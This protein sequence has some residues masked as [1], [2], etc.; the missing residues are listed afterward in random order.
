MTTMRDSDSVRYR[1]SAGEGV[2]CRDAG[3]PEEHVRGEHLDPTRS[4]IHSRRTSS[5]DRIGARRHLTT[6]VPLEAAGADTGGC[7]PEPPSARRRFG[8]GR[9]QFDCLAASS[10]GGEAG[11]DR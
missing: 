2:V 7:E 1:T 9:R 10:R 5:P 6:C 11:R 8:S 3:G 4:F